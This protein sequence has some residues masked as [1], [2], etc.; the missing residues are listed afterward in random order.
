MSP[1]DAELSPEER[2]N[3]TMIRRVRSLLKLAV[4]KD[5][6]KKLPAKEKAVIQ[7]QQWKE[8]FK[9]CDRNGSGT[10]SFADI[11]RMAR[12]QLKIAERLVSDADLQSFF[13]A[14]DEDGGGTV[15]F[16]EFLSFVNKPESNAESNE[17]IFQQ[18]KRTVRLSM[19][20][21][22]LTLDE[23]NRRFHNS[24][25]EGIVDV[26]NGDGSL[27][28]E[29]MRRFFR[30]VLNVSKH[31]APD[32]NLVIAFQAMDEDGGGTLD[33]EEFLDFIRDALEDDSQKRKEGDPYHPGLLGGMAGCLPARKPRFRPGTVPATGK[34]S[35]APFCLHGRF[36][37]PT[38]R[39]AKSRTPACVLPMR[40]RPSISQ[41]FLRAN[42]LPDIMVSPKEAVAPEKTPQGSGLA[43]VRTFGR[44]T[45]VGSLQ[46]SP[47][48]A[49][50]LGLD[51][52]EPINDNY[53]GMRGA[54][55]LN[56]VEHFLFHAGIDVRGHFH[57]Q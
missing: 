40:I 34:V 54:E 39:L 12:I 16:Q 41:P 10:L 17:R 31:E 18:V 11:K 22:G 8:I 7:A 26:A 6:G 20:K 9:Q 46:R 43:S 28:P 45:S 51:D 15:D 56:R 29:E 32:R 37:E 19:W 27:G 35:T 48:A 25:E 33:S 3:E 23:V 24:A 21:Q 4:N 2:E 47:T 30:K 38:G 14:I 55:P 36:L 42:G 52:E 53:H 5:G 13:S 50:R 49:V 1:K 44:A 57:K